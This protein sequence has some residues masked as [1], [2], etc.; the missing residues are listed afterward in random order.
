MMLSVR[1]VAEQLN[2]SQRCVYD[3]VA[4]GLLPH[5]RI[6]IGRGSIRIDPD[7]LAR[8]LADRRVDQQPETRR[9]AAQPKLKHIRLSS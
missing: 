4:K 1:D 5:H 3:L 2:V 7:D 9:R 8:F 6:G